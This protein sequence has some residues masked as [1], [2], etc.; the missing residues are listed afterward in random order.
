M[1]L[2]DVPSFVYPPENKK[3]G[4]LEQ[5]LTVDLLVARSNRVGF[6]LFIEEKSTRTNIIPWKK[7]LLGF[8]D[9]FRPD[10]LSD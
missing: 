9:L 2:V 6:L 5:K 7:A 8:L 10:A 4:P 1:R 3:W